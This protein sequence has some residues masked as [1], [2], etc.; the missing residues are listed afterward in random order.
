MLLRT[1][2]ESIVTLG[3]YICNVF[4]FRKNLAISVLESCW[5]CGVVLGPCVA[6]VLYD[7]V[8]LSLTFAAIGGF[9]ILTSIVTAS[10]LTLSVETVTE[11][12]STAT[13]TWYQIVKTNGKFNFFH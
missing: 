10:A 9:M 5:G 12:D 11:T 7:S 6:G 13:V 8:G 1:G 4:P 3:L 2:I